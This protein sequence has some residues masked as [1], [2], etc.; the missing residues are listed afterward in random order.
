MSFL[1]CLQMVDMLLSAADESRRVHTVQIDGSCFQ[2]ECLTQG[3]SVG[4]ITP[5]ISDDE[6]FIGPLPADH[7][8]HG[9]RT[10]NGDENGYDDL[11]R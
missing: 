7:G 5:Q 11:Y 1:L 2:S 3:G 6:L 4:I 9:E 10:D 8:H